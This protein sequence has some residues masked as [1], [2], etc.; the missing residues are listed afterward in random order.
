MILTASE[1]AKP[2]SSWV[3]VY[4]SDHLFGVFD[5]YA[6]PAES[7]NWSN[8]LVVTMSSGAL[9]YC[10]INRGPVRVVVQLL[11]SAPRRVDTGPWDDIVEASVHAPNGNLRVHQ[12]EYDATESAPPLPLISH[13]GPGSYR[14]RVHVRGRDLHYDDVQDDPCED[15]LLVAWPA[16]PAPDLIIRATDNTGYELRDGSL[17]QP[18]PGRK[19]DLT[20]LELAEQQ[21]QDLIEQALQQATI[22][23]RAES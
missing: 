18:D 15:Y 4:A 22:A 6:I 7:A 19:T 8:G 2:V 16:R 3:N 11:R 23:Y 13:K 20:E 10:G 5:D 14:L 17:E 1:K 12:L 21:R 9:V